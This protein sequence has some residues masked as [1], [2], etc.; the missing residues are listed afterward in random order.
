MR[1]FCFKMVWF[2]SVFLLFVSKLFQQGQCFM[3]IN[4]TVPSFLGESAQ[5]EGREEEEAR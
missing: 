3:Y 5:E 4:L 1:Y 2:S